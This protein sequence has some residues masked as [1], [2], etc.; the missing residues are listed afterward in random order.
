MTPIQLLIKEIRNLTP[1]PAITTRIINMADNP[2]C[3]MADIA[4]LIQY[5]P[6]MT[7]HM[8]R[9]CNS[10]FF[11]LSNPVESVKDAVAI[12]GID[13][14]VEL[15]LLNAGTKPL[16]RP[17]KGYGMR[18]GALWKHSVA[19]ALIAKNLATKQCPDLRHTIFTA[20]LLKDIGKV[21]LDKFILESMQKIESL[22]KQ[23]GLSFIEAEKKLSVQT[24]LKLEE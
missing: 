1:V 5:D 9:T 7:A 4:K 17:Q 20:A 13:K 15:V 6:A 8:L 16:A 21:V 23:N 19:S 18:K 3:D 22:I 12:L 14:I 10:A 24:M 2:S 11:G